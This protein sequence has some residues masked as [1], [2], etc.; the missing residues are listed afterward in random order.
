MSREVQGWNSTHPAFAEVIGEV[1][2]K[3]IIEVGSWRGASAIHMARLA[4][5]A[6]IYCVDT[7]LG[8]FEHIKDGWI[9]FGGR[10]NLYN[11]FLEN[12][13]HL[14]EHVTPI[15]LPSNIAAKVFAHKKMT[16]DLVYIDGSHEYEDVKADLKNYWPLVNSGGVMFGDD[17]DWPDV[18]KAVEEFGTPRIHGNKFWS[19][20]K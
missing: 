5:E 10:P 1:R 8:S 3:T 7:W 6:K 14:G 2:P 17:W 18:R 15:C 20:K 11:Q 9:Q 4:P 16:A 19:F 13:D 12:I